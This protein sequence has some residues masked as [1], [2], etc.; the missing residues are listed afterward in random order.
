[1]SEPSVSLTFRKTEPIH[2]SLIGM[3]GV[4][5]SYWSKRMEDQ[6]YRRY[7]CDELI[8]ERL[9]PELQRKGK[10]TLNLAKWMGLPYS[11]GYS[12]AEALYLELEGAVIT[13]I[14]EELETPS[15]INTPVVVD[16]T[17][18]LICLEKSLLKRLRTLTLMVYLNLPVEKNE[19]LFATYL[20]D[21]K[22]LIW[23]GKY[24]P[25]EGETTQNALSRCYEELVSF[26]NERYGLMADSVLDYSFHHS[27]GTGVEELLEFVEN[28]TKMNP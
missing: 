4:G 9:G 13:Q 7:S 1:M 18:S 21:P 5:K 8:A 11:E 25:R 26:R 20:S 12:E 28:S 24:L 10:S 2:I 16:S 6:G 17:G 3:S 14:C 19:Q 23:E 15:E 22:P 27:P